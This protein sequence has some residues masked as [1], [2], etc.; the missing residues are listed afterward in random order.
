MSARSI[1]TITRG[2]TQATRLACAQIM[3]GISETLAAV[4]RPLAD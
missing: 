1:T 4:D 2:P 3:G